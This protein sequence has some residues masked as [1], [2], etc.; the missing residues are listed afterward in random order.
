MIYFRSFTAAKSPSDG[1]VQ[2]CY[3]SSRISIFE[4]QQS[5]IN[6]RISIFEYQQ[7]N[8][9]SRISIADIN[10]RRSIVE[11]QYSHFNGRR[12]IVEY[13]QSNINIRI[14]IFEYQQ[15]NINS[16]I[17]KSRISIVEHQQSNIKN[18]QIPI[19]EYIHYTVIVPDFITSV[20]NSSSDPLLFVL[21]LSSLRSPS[22]PWHSFLRWGCQ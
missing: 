17:K 6:V 1:R 13:Q 19:V 11:Y 2:S 12:S 7:S 8:I 9:N 16:R 20:F 4:Y 18:S 5:K 14:S 10:S 3:R 15:S 22:I 21:I